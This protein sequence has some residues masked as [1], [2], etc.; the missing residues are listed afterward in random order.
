MPAVPMAERFLLCAACAVAILPTGAAVAE[1]ELSY[2]RGMHHFNRYNYQHEKKEFEQA[3]PTRSRRCAIEP[4]MP[5]AQI[6]RGL[7]LIELGR[8]PALIRVSVAGGRRA[9]RGV[10]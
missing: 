9:F 5:V 7:A 1:A 2:Q 6:R 10:Q 4:D 8:Q 3:W